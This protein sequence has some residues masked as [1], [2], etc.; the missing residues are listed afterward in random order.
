MDVSKLVADTCLPLACQVCIDKLGAKKPVLAIDH[1]LRQSSLFPGTTD[2]NWHRDTE[3][4]AAI[5]YS[6]VVKLTPGTNT[7]QFQVAGGP[8]FTYGPSCGAYGAFLADLVHT[9]VSAEGPEHAY[10]LGLFYVEQQ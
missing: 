3:D 9:S 2:F 1:F 4:L 6:I 7:N 10:K 5:K 8:V